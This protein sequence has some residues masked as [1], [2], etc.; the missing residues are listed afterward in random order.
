MPRKLLISLLLLWLMAAPAL[1]QAPCTRAEFLTIFEQTADLQLQL[2]ASLGTV[3]DLL[4]FSENA[5][6]GRQNMTTS[7]LDCADA[8]EYQLMT[9]EVTGD[10]IARQA[11]NLA[12]VPQGDNPYRL[13]FAGEQERI[14]TSLSAM[15]SR[16]RNDAP[17]AEERSLPDCSADEISELEEL[18]AE[19]LALLDSSD[20]SDDL[21]Y[22]LLAIDARLLWREE[23]LQGRPGCAEWLELLPTLSAAATDSAADYAVG[24]IVAG[25]GNP[26]AGSV[27]RH[28]ARLRH[29]LSP[30]GAALSVP[31]GATIASSG[32]PAC[33]PAELGQA[34]DILKSNYNSLLATAGQISDISGLQRYSEAYLQFRA[35]QLAGLPL[36]AEAFSAGWEAR[37]LL[38][39][40]AIW[41]AFDLINPAGEQHPDREAL[42]E[43][44]AR[45]AVAIEDLAS[46]LAGINGLSSRAPEESLLACSRL[47]VQFLRNYLLPA[48]DE[49]SQAA[50][51]LQRPAGLPELVESSY[52][53]RQ[54][55][56]LELPRCA[57]ALEAGLVMR[58]I[59]ADLVALIGLEAAGIPAVDVPYLHGVAADMSW[60]AARLGELT[61]DL[62]STD[63]AGERY[64]VIAER[65]ANIRSCASTDCRVVATVLAGDTVYAADDSDAWYRLNLPDKQTGYIAGYL[66]SST[67]P[68]DS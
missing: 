56:W 54:L 64:F 62:G 58:R 31:S 48:F 7:Q 15:L 30:G 46:R 29:W 2:D 59:A 61:G 47:E 43:A 50:L 60:L 21:A 38:G 20:A 12:N 41:A 25:A 3:A 8:L 63:I 27:A 45:V 37:Q 65:G 52:A 23:A 44:S 10:F 35:E 68:P 28:I 33:S 42:M 57:G 32:L 4:S 55:L 49:F 39:G 16:D 40:L 53:L 22:A 24:A 14:E 66:V 11:L 18:V 34:Y 13:R 5:I 51:S 67:P 1:A 17:A 6:A 19:L 9:I 36:C 26:F